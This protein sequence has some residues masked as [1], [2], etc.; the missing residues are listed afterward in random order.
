MDHARLAAR[1]F[2]N[3]STRAYYSPRSLAVFLPEDEVDD[4]TRADRDAYRAWLTARL[5]L[6][7]HEYQHALDHVGTVAGR[8]L[9]DALA[10]AYFALE[11]KAARDE[12]ELWRLVALH[13]AERRF[14]R[15]AYFTEYDP[16]YA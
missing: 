11:R 14:D 7:T 2:P 3:V 13:D 15:K 9:L 12:T 1:Y 6:L 10:G 16:D 4:A 5:P 8:A